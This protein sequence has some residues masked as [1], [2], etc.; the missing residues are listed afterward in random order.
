MPTTRTRYS[1]LSPMS[2]SDSVSVFFAA[3]DFFSIPGQDKVRKTIAI[4]QTNN[5]IHPLPAGSFMDYIKALNIL[6]EPDRHMQN[7]RK[8]LNK[9]EGVGLLVPMGNSGSVFFPTN[10]YFL[11][12][13]T[14]REKKGRFWLSECLGPEYVYKF[15]GNLIIHIVGMTSDGDEHGGTGVIINDKLVLTCKHVIDEMVI[16][17][18]QFIN[19]SQIKVVNTHTHNE[20]DV[21]IIEF[22]PNSFIVNGN[23]CFDSPHLNDDIYVLGYPPIPY[24]KE[25]API[26]QKGEITNP[27]I[28][29]LDNHTVFLFSAIARPGNSGG[30]IIAR[31]GRILGIVTKEL[32]L[33]ESNNFP[34]FAGIPTNEIVTALSDMGF[35]G[36]LPVENYQ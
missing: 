33:R 6:A 1:F 8:L 5:G 2:I 26:M 19:G 3:L 34:F 35:G 36:I 7:I 12:E 21:G 17:D 9:M 15:F 11:K 29:T 25:V 23:V 30:P 14:E 20:I 13:L 27:E 4:P 32:S 10:Y 28:T 18:T 24:S 16:N 31:N 22:E